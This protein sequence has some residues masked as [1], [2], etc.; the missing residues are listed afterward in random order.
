M[1]PVDTN[2]CDTDRLPIDYR[3]LITYD[4]SSFGRGVLLSSDRVLCSDLSIVKV[5]V[6]PFDHVL[7]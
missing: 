3:L 2:S 4:T 7:V 6:V 5:K 1:D